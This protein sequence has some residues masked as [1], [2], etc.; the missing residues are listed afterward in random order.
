MVRISNLSMPKTNVLCVF[1]HAQPNRFICS[2]NVV[3][4]SPFNCRIRIKTESF[5]RTYYSVSNCIYRIQVLFFKLNEAGIL[6]CDG[7]YYG[8]F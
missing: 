3:R 7:H 2:A 6:T 4:V 5:A 1:I 8:I